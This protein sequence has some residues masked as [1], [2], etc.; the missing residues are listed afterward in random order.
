MPTNSLE[1]VSVAVPLRLY[2]APIPTSEL[3]NRSPTRLLPPLWLMEV[4]P[5]KVIMDETLRLPWDCCRVMLFVPP[6]PASTE[7]TGALGGSKFTVTAPSF[8]VSVTTAVGD[9]EAPSL[10]LLPTLQLPL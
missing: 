1:D 9:G 8:D 4:W 7:I 3:K 10:Q 5:P 6:A 2:T